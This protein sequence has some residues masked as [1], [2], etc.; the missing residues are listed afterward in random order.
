MSVNKTILLGI[1]GGD[2]DI[3]VLDN[4][5]KVANFSLATNES[6]KNKQGEKVTDTEWHRIVAFS[7]LADIIE[8]WVK[9]GSKIYVEGKNKTRSWDKDGVKIYTTEVHIR[10]MTMLGGDNQNKPQDQQPATQTN[11]IDQMTQVDSDDLP[12]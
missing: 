8:K 2:P 5:K 4:G 3:R 6:Y 1:L 10:E 7:P 12:F 11:V 9:K